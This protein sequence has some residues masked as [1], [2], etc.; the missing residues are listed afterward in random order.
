MIRFYTDFTEPPAVTGYIKKGKNC[1]TFSAWWICFKMNPLLSFLKSKIILALLGF[2]LIAGAAGFW[3]MANRTTLEMTADLLNQA[4]LI[5][6]TINIDH[7]KALTGTEADLSSPD[8]QRIKQLLS[9]VKSANSRYRF[10]YLFGHKSDGTL[11]FFVDSEPVDSADY[12]AP[13]EIYLE[14]SEEARRVFDTRTAMMEGP[15]SDRW[16]TWVS[17]LVPL[18]DPATGEVLVLVGMDIDASDWNWQVAVRSALPM[19]LLLAMIFLGLTC[20]LLYRKNKLNSEPAS[21]NAGK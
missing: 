13:G 10:L 9:S 20:V 5:T 8:Y 18:I 21:E 15:V 14:S 11:F 6:Q 19:G 3:W 12:S 2:I 4:R 1:L 7:I 16:G 17:T